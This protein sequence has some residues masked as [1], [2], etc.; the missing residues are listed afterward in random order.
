VIRLCLA[1]IV[2]DV[3]PGIASPRRLEDR[4]AGA[5]LAGLRKKSIF[6]PAGVCTANPDVRK[7]SRQAALSFMSWSAGHASNRGCWSAIS[8]HTALVAVNMRDDGLHLGAQHRPDS[9]QPFC[10]DVSACAMIAAT[11]CANARRGPLDPRPGATRRGFHCPAAGSDG[12][13]LTHDTD[14]HP[15]E[16]ASETDRLTWLQG[17]ITCPSS[18][19][20]ASSWR[21]I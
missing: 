3:T 5:C 4:M 19:R 13:R 21:L 18:S 8:R 14:G 2:L 15:V 16:C 20:Q 1:I 11:R 10:D 9:L 17:P 7:R 12:P 6:S